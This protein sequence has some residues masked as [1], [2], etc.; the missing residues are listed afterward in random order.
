MNELNTAPVKRR[1]R[2]VKR[3]ERLTQDEILKSLLEDHKKSQGE[4]VWIKIDDRTHIELPASL[5]EEDRKK[6]VKNYLEHSNFKPM[7]RL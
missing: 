6:R 1:G 7:K 5:S 2:T 3:N 4:V